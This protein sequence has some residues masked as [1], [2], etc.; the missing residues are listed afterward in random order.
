[1][2]FCPKDKQLMCEHEIGTTTGGRIINAYCVCGF[3][4]TT[5]VPQ[6]PEPK[7]KQWLKVDWDSIHKLA[8]E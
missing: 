8:N 5:A 7:V 1:M 4:M 3:T 6:V 2:L